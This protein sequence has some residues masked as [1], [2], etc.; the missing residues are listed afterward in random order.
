MPNTTALDPTTTDLRQSATGAL[1][2]VND[3]TM[4]LARRSRVLPAD[5]S[6]YADAVEAYLAGLAEGQAF[7]P[8]SDLPQPPETD[9]L[10]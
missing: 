7:G 6:D 2:Y 3:V 9:P 4:R 5:W 8:I 1:W 10:A